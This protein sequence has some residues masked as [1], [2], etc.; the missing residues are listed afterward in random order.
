MAKSGSRRRIQ[1]LDEKRSALSGK[2]VSGTAEDNKSTERRRTT[3]AENPLLEN[4]NQGN[5]DK[6]VTKTEKKQARD[7]SADERLKVD[8]ENVYKD[9][10]ET[11]QDL[12]NTSIGAEELDEQ[13]EGIQADDE[14]NDQIETE[15]AVNPVEKRQAEMQKILSSAGYANTMSSSGGFQQESNVQITSGKDGV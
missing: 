5:E 15:R 2:H 11:P 7:Q 3:N 10:V 6:E 14:D 9:P 8:K 1:P 13:E 12:K 4:F